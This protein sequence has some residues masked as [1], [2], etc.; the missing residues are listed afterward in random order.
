MQR[1]AIVGGV[2]GLGTALVFGA[3]ALTAT[4]FPNGPMVVSNG[5]MFMDKQ[6]FGGGI[7]PVPQPMPVVVDDGTKGIDISTATDPPVPA[8]QP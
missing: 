3:A 5:G 4:L 6:V 8:G 2:L 7:A 1:A